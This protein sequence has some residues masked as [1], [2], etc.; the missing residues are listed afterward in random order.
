MVGYASEVTG[1]RIAAVSLW[2]FHSMHI[3]HLKLIP[4]GNANVVF[5]QTGTGALRSLSLQTRI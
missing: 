1:Q 3:L 4:D 2:L 5:V